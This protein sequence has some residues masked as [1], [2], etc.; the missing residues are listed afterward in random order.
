[1][2]RASD[3]KKDIEYYLNLS[4]PVQLTHQCDDDDEYWIAEVLD[5][6]GCVSDGATPDEAV[7]NVEDAK[8]LW[9]ETQIED[10]LEVPEPTHT[11]GYSGKFLLRL[12]RTLHRRLAE[13]AKREDVSL[14]QSV[15]NMLSDANATARHI[16]DIRRSLAL[17]SNEVCLLRRALLA[18]QQQPNRLDSA[19]VH[20]LMGVPSDY[21]VR[22]R[23]IGNTVVIG[24]FG[25]GI[26]GVSGGQAE[27]PWDM[28]HPYYNMVT[29]APDREAAMDVNVVGAAGR[30]LMTQG[31]RFQ[32]DQ[33]LRETLSD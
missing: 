22:N 27:E 20:D 8:H 25:S 7:E 33:I 11:S 10:G 14:N 6:P 4:Y 24:N 32:S 16:G 2:S 17:L 1:M 18:M 21:A 26:A 31:H 15:V 23:T 13:Q 5:L 9:I 19:S 29:T 3:Q 30:Y 28:P 12:P